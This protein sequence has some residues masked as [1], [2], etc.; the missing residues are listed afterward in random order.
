MVL[1]SQATGTQGRGRSPRARM[2]P[3]MSSSNVG[4]ILSGPHF[5]NRERGGDPEELRN[6]R[7]G[8][9]RV[10]SRSFHGEARAMD[11]VEFRLP[12]QESV[13]PDGGSSDVFR[14]PHATRVTGGKVATRSVW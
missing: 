2:V 10:S 7:A 4:V 9:V 12:C 6:R 1:G 3:F 14:A 13:F 5:E 11:F 8:V